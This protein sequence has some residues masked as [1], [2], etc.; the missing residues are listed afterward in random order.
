L[1]WGG[2]VSYTNARKKR[3]QLATFEK[4][5][6]ERRSSVF[7]RKNT[8]GYIT[9]FLAEAKNFSSNLCVQTR[10]GTRPASYPMGTGVLSPG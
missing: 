5:L 1:V 4:D 10:T 2:G 3:F 8:L 9:C 7:C 6:L